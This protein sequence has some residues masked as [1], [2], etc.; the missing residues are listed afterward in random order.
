V[1]EE[2]QTAGNKVIEVWALSRKKYK[3]KYKGKGNGKRGSQDVQSLSKVRKGLSKN[4][5]STRRELLE[6]LEDVGA[7]PILPPKYEP[8]ASVL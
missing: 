6:I 5:A 4:G 2:R 7:L 3:Y 8:S 1:L